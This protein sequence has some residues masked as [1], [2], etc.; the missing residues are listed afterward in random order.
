MN[1]L[2]IQLAKLAA[3]QHLVVTRQQALSLGMTRRQIQ[4]RVGVGSLI[5][6]H[7]G[8]YR[9]VGAPETSSKP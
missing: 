3:R 4:R 8:A 9:L 7:N 6:V 1:P 2:E 5:V